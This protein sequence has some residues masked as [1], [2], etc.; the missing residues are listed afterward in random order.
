MIRISMTNPLFADDRTQL[1][2]YS[3]SFLLKSLED[4]FTS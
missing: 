2:L 4:S 3:S 1:Q